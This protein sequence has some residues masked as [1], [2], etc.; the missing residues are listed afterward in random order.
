MLADFGSVAADGR[1][2]YVEAGVRRVE[3]MVREKG[4]VMWPDC[5]YEP[6]DVEV[7]LYAAHFLVEAE[8]SGAALEEGAKKRVMKFLARWAMSPANSVSAYACHT[9]ALAGKP[10]RDRMLR[11][12]I[13]RD[14]L[15]LVSRA[16]LARGFVM[17]GER[18]FATELLRSA[19]SPASVKEAAF[20]L[21]AMLELDPSDARI[22]ALVSYL[23]SKRGGE[24]YSW[25]TTGDNAHAL[26][27]LGAYY[28]VRRPA[29]GA[30]FVC[31]R[32]LE[33]PDAASVTNEASEISAERRYYTAEGELADLD[34][35]K[36]GDLLVA[37][38]AIR[39][40][41]S[42]DLSDLVVEDLF[43]GAFE[44][45]H[46]PLDAK[47]CPWIPRGGADW[48]MRSDA[49]DDRMLVFSKKF[50]L[51]AGGEVKFHYPL[52]VVSPGEFALPGVAVEAM[53][54]PSIRARTAPARC[55]ASPR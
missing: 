5:N 20:A 53:Y 49:R 10:D 24:R 52:R 46:S 28:R 32:A 44:P 23:G 11:L 34:A 12:Y 17:T 37:E 45:V 29:K 2:K 36:C 33:L 18:A 40:E 35:L 30:R 25:G 27:A 1:A 6:W 55:R 13:G 8:R 3:S 38:I 42:R 15:D 48:V 16:R 22:P 51:E 7:S 39:S 54:Q 41:A 4:F 9:L 43:A 26:L 21:L 47:L 14:R 31:W 50:R 19:D